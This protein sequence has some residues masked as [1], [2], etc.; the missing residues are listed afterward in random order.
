MD[1]NGNPTEKGAEILKSLKID[2]N[3]LIERSLEDFMESEDN[4]NATKTMF[5]SSREGSKSA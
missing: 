5:F 2:P 1:K 4:S 3:D